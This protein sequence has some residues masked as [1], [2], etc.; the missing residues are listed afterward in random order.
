MKN[1]YDVII[2]G[3]GPGGLKCAE[4]LKNSGLSVLLIEKNKIIGPKVCAG[5][6]TNLTTHF[7]LP[8]NKTRVFEEA[9]IYVVKR[10]YEMKLST[11]IRIIDR[12]ELGQHML[13]KIKNV[14][15]ITILKDTLVKS[16]EK[17]KIKTTK[18]IFHFKYLVGA[19][20]TSSAVR[21]YL[22]LE[23]KIYMGIQYIIPVKCSEFVG[24]VN[25][26]LISSGY[27][28]IFPH[29]DFT[30]AGVFFNPR[31][32][33]VA[34]AKTQLNNFLDDY[35]VDYKNAKYEGAPANCLFK[36]IQFNNIFLVGDAAGLTSANTGEGISFALTSGEEVARKIINPV[37]KMIELDKLLKIKKIQENVLYLFDRLPFLQEPLFRIFFSLFKKK[38]F[39]S[40]YGN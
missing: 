16:I 7:D 40:Y 32:I 23:N 8:N 5:G 28:W 10:I 31:I 17:D 27:G 37:Y 11:P 9:K 18:G 21:R 6:L 34:K 24:F 29:K 30:S 22:G 38:W 19:D 36:G 4:G 2:I 20:G 33:S 3:A 15:N 14:K 25:P 13:K 1:Q 35:G 39:Q 12:Y 26:K